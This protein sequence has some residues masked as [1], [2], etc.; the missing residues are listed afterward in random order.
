MHRL[1]G[2]RAGFIIE[3]IVHAVSSQ[4][5][6]WPSVLA[7]DSS[8]S[9]KLHNCVW[10]LCHCIKFL[11]HFELCQLVFAPTVPLSIG[12]QVDY[13]PVPCLQNAVVT[14]SYYAQQKLMEIP[15]YCEE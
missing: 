5:G 14:V 4:I 8:S 1:F 3:Y 7:T 6:E 9:Y 13:R 11:L 10:L 2:E 15:S 12:P